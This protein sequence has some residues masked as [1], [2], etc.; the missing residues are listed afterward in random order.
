MAVLSLQQEEGSTR[1]GMEAGA[2]SQMFSAATDCLLGAEQIA[3]QEITSNESAIVSVVSL[4]INESLHRNLTAFDESCARDVVQTDAEEQAARLTICGGEASEA[5]SVYATVLAAVE[6]VWR[7]DIQEAFMFGTEVVAL[8]QEEDSDRI[9]LVD[10]WEL[11]RELIDRRF[12]TKC[13]KID[14][15]AFLD[16][17]DDL[18]AELIHMMEEQGGRIALSAAE[19]ADREQV[20][21]AFVVGAAEVI[22]DALVVEEAA[23]YTLLTSLEANTAS[24]L[25]L[26]LGET[27]ARA[28]LEL[29]EDHTRG[30]LALTT[31]EVTHRLTTAAEELLEGDLLFGNALVSEESVSRLNLQQASCMTE[32]AAA[33][34]AGAEEVIRDALVVEEAACYTLLTSLEANTASLLTLELG[35][36][37]ARATLELEEDHTRDV[38]QMADCEATHRLTT[39][40]EEDLEGA[41]LFGTA[42]LSE[43]S[44]SRSRLNVEQASCMAEITTALVV[45]AEEVLRDALVAEEAERYALLTSLTTN[46]ASLLSLEWTETSA[47]ATLELEEG[48]TRDVLRLTTCEATHRLTTAAE[49]HSE[50]ALLFGNALVSEEIVCRLNLEQASCMAEIAASFVARA[51]KIARHELDSTLLETLTNLQFTSHA[52]LTLLSIEQEEATEFA[53]LTRLE[54]MET[55]RM[56][57]YLQIRAEERLDRRC[58]LLFAAESKGRA[59]LMRGPLLK[60]RFLLLRKCQSKYNHFKSNLEHLL[61]LSA[62]EAGWKS[63]FTK[64]G[65]CFSSYEPDYVFA[66]KLP[67][68]KVPPTPVKTPCHQRLL[69][70]KAATSKVLLSTAKKCAASPE[71]PLRTPTTVSRPVTRAAADSAAHKQPLPKTAA[72][73]PNSRLRSHSTKLEAS[74]NS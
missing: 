50:G 42:L 10:E 28:T 69:V 58:M 6:D 12:L 39:A 15:E 23:C 46:T 49:E 8:D 45:G 11:H 35:E 74:E 71:L 64:S 1:I 66:Q 52:T 53:I 34:V 18:F 30:V 13:E 3:R 41:S 62:L 33:F 31:C 60:E 2:D 36:T 24:L 68:S 43:E 51:E 21:S 38:L 59:S 27:S 4:E 48:H 61:G 73:N 67:P 19:D 63:T 44:V 72:R 9:E 14:R 25:T 17:E 5:V 22:R 65:G 26:E 29:E 40:A 55:E 54:G 37:S 47:R 57:G 70:E 32:I 20:A 56:S 7:G 16:E